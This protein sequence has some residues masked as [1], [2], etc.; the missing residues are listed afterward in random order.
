M[1]GVARSSASTK[2]IWKRS[3]AF[4]YWEVSLTSRTT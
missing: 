1:G 4:T 2:S 3:S